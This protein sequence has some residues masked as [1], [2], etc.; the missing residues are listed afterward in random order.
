MS[1]HLHSDGNPVESATP[2]LNMSDYT[3]IF[4]QKYE[5][6]L[7]I[8]EVLSNDSDAVN[9]GKKRCNLLTAPKALMSMTLK[10]VVKVQQQKPK[11]EQQ[12]VEHNSVL[13]RSHFSTQKLA[14]RV[15]K[16]Y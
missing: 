9:V 12:Q 16:L 8:Q 10:K 7:G 11:K 14:K 3:E 13:L 6:I 4:K 5:I 1:R 2:E 15:Q